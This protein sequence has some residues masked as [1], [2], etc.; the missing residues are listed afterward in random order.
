MGEGLGLE[1]TLVDS[2]HHNAAGCHARHVTLCLCRVSQIIVHPDFV[3]TSLVNDVSLL[4]LAGDGI[5]DNLLH[6]APLNANAAAELQGAPL[7]VAGW[8]VTDESSTCVR[9]LPAS[10]R[11]KDADWQ[12]HNLTACPPAFP[13]PYVCRQRGD[14]GSTARAHHRD[15]AQGVCPG[16][17]RHPVSA[18]CGGAAGWP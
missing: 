8:G 13:R 16:V 17:H 10:A 14:G 3:G 12:Q 4:Q 6:P 15:P 1:S 11:V 18:V 7:L 2:G 9:M 5:P